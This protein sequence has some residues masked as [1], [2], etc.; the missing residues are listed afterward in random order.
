MGAEVGPIHRLAI[1]LVVSPLTLPNGSIFFFG[2][3]LGEVPS[4]MVLSR[5]RPS[6]YLPGM[7]MMWGYVCHPLLATFTDQL[8]F[9]PR[10]LSGLTALC[11]SY[12]QL[13]AFRFLLGYVHT[14]PQPAKY[15]PRPK[16]N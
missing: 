15:I 2:Y 9:F 16:H 1:Y 8:K 14:N 6:Y 12:H 13:L 5:S 7:M 4:N 11:K 3:V 10:I